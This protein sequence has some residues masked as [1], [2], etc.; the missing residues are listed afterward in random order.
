VSLEA[1]GKVKEGWGW[2]RWDLRDWSAAGNKIYRQDQDDME[3]EL[4][5]VRE[6]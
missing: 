6:K 4:E 3:T 2:A 1:D 5:I